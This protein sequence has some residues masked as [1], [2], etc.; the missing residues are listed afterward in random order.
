MEKF[1]AETPS[2]IYIFSSIGI[3][4]AIRVWPSDVY[5]WVLR[6]QT[7]LEQTIVTVCI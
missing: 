2:A 6:L 7:C 4:K 1:A 3:V 5:D